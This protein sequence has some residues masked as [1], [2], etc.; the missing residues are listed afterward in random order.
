MRN[1]ELSEQTDLCVKCGLCL[2]HCPTYRL[3]ADEN[4]SPRGR[5]SLI[6]GWA[7]AEL[8]ADEKLLAHTRQC[9]LCR[10]CEAVCPA[11]V[12][13]GSIMDRFRSLNPLPDNA[14]TQDQKT[15]MTLVQ[16]T[17]DGPFKRLLQGASRSGSLRKAADLLG[18]GDLTQGLP[19]PNNDTL[20][21]A[22]LHPAK[23]PS[24]GK[25][26]LFMGCT[27]EMLD[28]A[29]ARSAVTLLTAMGYEVE[30]PRTQ[31]CCGA[32]D[33]HAGRH[34]AALS[35]S[36][37]NQTAFGAEETTPVVS[38]ASGCASTFRDLS[39][40]ANPSSLGAR[41]ED[42]SAFIARAPGRE[43]LQFRALETTVCLH[44]PCTLKHVLKADRFAGELLRTCLEAPITA[45]PKSSGCC[46]AAGSYMIE[47]PE[48]SRAL[49]REVVDAI[50]ASG[51]TLLVTSNPGCASHLRSGVRERGLND[52]E[53]LHPITL[54][55]RQLEA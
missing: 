39:P 49:Q 29:T 6:Q 46:G 15:R 32:L 21:A 1:Q 34:A 43:R 55:A 50:V 36:E 48:T 23:G 30:I 4:E 20:P 33:L 26:Q 13:Y 47:H 22:G 53:V 35:K 40:S 5:L 7:R 37:Q 2:P 18:Y 14:Q 28:L 3:S 38:F 31:T 8:E 16:Q 19:E 44:S 12:P 25:V 9:V 10:A 45:L 41:M 27:V 17:L 51:A 24:L 42:I 11:Y 52:M 54:L